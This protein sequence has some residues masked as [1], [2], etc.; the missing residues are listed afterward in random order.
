MVEG[1]DARAGGVERTPSPKKLFYCRSDRM[2]IHLKSKELRGPVDLQTRV[3]EQ[4]GHLFVYY[5]N[6]LLFSLTGNVAELASVLRSAAEQ[7]EQQTYTGAEK[8]L[9]QGEA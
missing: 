7:L 1:P 5:S 3:W 6:T 2:A 4:G 8:A 9:L